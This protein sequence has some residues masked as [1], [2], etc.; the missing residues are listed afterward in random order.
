[1]MLNAEADT[2]APP[3]AA[4]L[5]AGVCAPDAQQNVGRERILVSIFV[6]AVEVTAGGSSAE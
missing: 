4:A 5:A 1:M 2:V 3:A 6:A